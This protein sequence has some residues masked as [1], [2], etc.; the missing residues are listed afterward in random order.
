VIGMVGKLP[1]AHRAGRLGFR[2]AGDEVALVGP[3]SPSLDA[4]ELAKLRGEA[5]PGALAELELES[6]LA[7]Q[8]AV[9]EAVAAGALASAHD[10]AEGG[11]AVALAE[12]CLAGQIGAAV[13]LSARAWGA[14][15]AD[16]AP[17]AAL[18]G[19]APGGFLVSGAAGALEALAAR[20]RVLVLGNVGG[21][22]LRIT[23][24]GGELGATLAEL[25]AAH[26]RLEECFE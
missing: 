9:R 4:S 3:F 12:C 11:L 15:V 10:I 23:Y 26:A 19:E 22:Q 24:P 1:D 18:F 8:A 6:V 7:A 2:S 17:L 20:A 14:L 21:E 13:E 25:A 16:A 5:L